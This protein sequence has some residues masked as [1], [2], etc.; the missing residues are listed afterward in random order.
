MVVKIPLWQYVYMPGLV[1]AAGPIA[2]IRVYWYKKDPKTAREEN[3]WGGMGTRD[4]AGEM[5]QVDAR[6]L[7]GFPARE[8]VRNK[9]VGKFWY[10]Q[11]LVHLERGD[12]VYQFVWWLK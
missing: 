11:W 6:W 2:E 4:F 7:Q 8:R 1:E 3:D 12:F 10:S 9:F 5:D